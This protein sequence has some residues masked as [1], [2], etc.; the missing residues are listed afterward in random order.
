MMNERIA[1]YRQ[2]QNYFE[3]DLFGLYRWGD[4]K[5]REPEPVAIERDDRGRR[6]NQKSYGRLV[7]KAVIEFDGYVLSLA[8]PNECPPPEPA[9]LLYDGLPRP[10][11]L[12]VKGVN[13]TETWKQIA[14]LLRD[15]IEKGKSHGRSEGSSSWG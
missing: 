10:E 15:N 3:R 9:V 7:E 12:V 5:H 14:R 1:L 8:S 6:I 11:N 2:L 4:V 13:C